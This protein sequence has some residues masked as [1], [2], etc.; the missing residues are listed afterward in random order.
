MNIVLII[1]LLNSSVL[2]TVNTGRYILGFLRKLSD[3]STRE[4]STCYRQ[5]PPILR[6]HLLFSSAADVL[7]GSSSRL[8]CVI[9][10]VPSM[11]SL[12]RMQSRCDY[13]LSAETGE[14]LKNIPRWT[15]NFKINMSA[16]SFQ[17]LMNIN[18][19]A[20]RTNQ[21]CRRS[22]NVFGQ[23]LSKITSF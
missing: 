2:M 4:L 18:Y 23:N 21:L 3:L 8:T 1:H 15:I 6:F 13:L 19:T 16:S 20:P 5:A 22:R 7:S 14:T 9:M 10:D 11:D 17:S 12:V